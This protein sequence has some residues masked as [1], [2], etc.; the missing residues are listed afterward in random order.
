M[1]DTELIGEGAISTYNHALEHLLVQDCHV[2]PD[3]ATIYVQLVESIECRDWHWLNTRALSERFKL[4]VAADDD[5]SINVAGDALLD[6]Q[7]TQF[8]EFTPLTEP[9][10]AFEFVVVICSIIR[11]DRRSTL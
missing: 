8:N 5:E 7:L 9:L 1:F 3:S 4:N 10:A 6:V 11:A 2:I